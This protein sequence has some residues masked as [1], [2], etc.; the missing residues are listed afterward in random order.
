MKLKRIILIIAGIITIGAI[1]ILTAVSSINNNQHK[2]EYAKAQLKNETEKVAQSIGLYLK[3]RHDSI[4][5]LSRVYSEEPIEDWNS[6]RM[7]ALLKDAAETTV[8]MDINICDKDGVGYDINGVKQEVGFCPLYQRSLLGESNTAYSKLYEDEEQGLIIDSVPILKDNSVIGVLRSATDTEL[9]LSLMSPISFRGNEDVYL[10]ERDGDIV[11]SISDKIADFSN[12]SAIIDQED[13][14]YKPLIQVINQGRSI[15]TDIYIDDEKYYVYYQG[16]D[17]IG[18]WGIMI[19]I[20]SSKLIELYSI[21]ATLETNGLFMGI[22]LL[23]IVITSALVII[24]ICETVRGYRMERMAY[25]DGVTGSMNLN[26]FRKSA[27]E[28][29]Q[30]KDNANIAVVQMSI[31]KFDYIREFFGIGEIRRIQKHIANVLRANMQEDEIFCRDSSKYFNLLLKY[32]NKEELANRIQ[33]LN[34]KLLSFKENDIDNNK[35]E[36]ILKYGIYPVT[37]KDN[38]VEY[39]VDKANQA[40]LLVREDRNQLMQYYSSSMNSKEYDE[41]EIE[42]RMYKAIEEKELVVYLQPKYDLNTGLQ[43]GAEALVRW[44]HPEKGIIYPGRFIHVFEKNGFI[45]K[46]DMYMLEQMCSMLS[47]WTSKGYRPKPLS[48]NISR[49]NL[50]DPKFSNN[51]LAI[52]E[53]YGV[54]PQLII[55]EISEETIVDN[56]DIVQQAMDKFQEYGFQ[57]SIDNF[58]TGTTSMNTLFHI[59]VDELKLDRKYILESEKTDRGLKV[60]KS[61]IETAKSL[62][63]KVVSDGV[64]NK[65]QA[66]QLK[67]MGCDMLQGFVFSEPLPA[68]EY[69]DYAYGPRAMENRIN[70]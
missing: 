65:K 17:G 66:Q 2:M 62:G 61:I 23:S 48:L 29:I 4:K 46:M 68:S 60:I 1:V 50:Y 56:M 5:L 14:E 10:V 51:V 30:K 7:N 35:Y 63:I 54:S 20:P 28:I 67:M 24:S 40:M 31:N 59:H 12:I 3:G 27:L 64:D 55:F 37:D 44:I 39:I 13:D 32:H 47:V 49:L 43:V 33:Y 26:S 69:E 36:F 34:S 45:G 16:I 19:A 58:G 70:L 6:S 41:K 25:Y 38:D 21:S 22:A 9:I 18:N 42:E 57:V 11:Q 52:L 8:F 53:R 15:F